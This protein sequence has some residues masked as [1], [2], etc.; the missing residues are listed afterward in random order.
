MNRE[1]RTG[2]RSK[3][4][5]IIT[6]PEARPSFLPMEDILDGIKKHRN[7]SMSIS[8]AEHREIHVQPLGPHMVPLTYYPQDTVAHRK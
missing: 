8:L 7:V 4:Y 5:V 3:A 2:E 6:R 1:D